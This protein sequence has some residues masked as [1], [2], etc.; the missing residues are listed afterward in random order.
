MQFSPRGEYVSCLPYCLGPH[1]YGFRIQA[2]ARQS[3]LETR[4]D[5]TVL[6]KF[7]LLNFYSCFIPPLV[8]KPSLHFSGV[9]K[10]FI[11]I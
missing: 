9:E 7:Y 1:K 10:I 11:F 6:R 8:T 5:T 2:E 3:I 4:H